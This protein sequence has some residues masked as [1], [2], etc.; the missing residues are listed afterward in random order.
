M[1]IGAMVES[2]RLGFKDGVKK[3]AELGIEGIQEYA[4]Y[5]ELNVDTIT[6]DKLKEALDDYL[7]NEYDNE[8]RS[9]K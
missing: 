9:K 2:F 1:K 7:D 5:G 4:T 3:A 8:R 6:D